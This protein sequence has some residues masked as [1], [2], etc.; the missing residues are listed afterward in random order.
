MFEEPTPH[1]GG[2]RAVVQILEGGLKRTGGKTSPT[3]SLVAAFR[4]VDFDSPQG[5]FRFDPV[6]PFPIINY[7]ILKMVKKE[8]K[9]GYEVLDVLKE[10]KP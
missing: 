4:Q 7:Y 2:K 5:R 8:G 1:A 10:V 9:L 6:K 3:E